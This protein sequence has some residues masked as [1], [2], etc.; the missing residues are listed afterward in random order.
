MDNVFGMLR[1]PIR[2]DHFALSR[3]VVADVLCSHLQ[4]SSFHVFLR[5]PVVFIGHQMMENT[6]S[7]TRSLFFAVIIGSATSWKA[8]SLKRSW[9]ELLVRTIRATS[10]PSPYRGQSSGITARGTEPLGRHCERARGPV[11]SP[12]HSCDANCWPSSGISRFLSVET[13]CKRKGGVCGRCL[14]LCSSRIDP[15]PRCDS[16]VRRDYSMSQ[17]MEE[18]TLVLQVLMHHF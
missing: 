16:V 17:R 4:C 5:S 2:Q 9:A 18:N 15:H 1:R 12:Q 8:S 6:T 14:F 3:A 7:G 11:T 13:Q 10:K